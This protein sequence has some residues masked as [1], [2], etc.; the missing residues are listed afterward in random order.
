MVCMNLNSKYLI[1]HGNL[2][3]Y[4]CLKVE[5][6]VPALLKYLE[7]TRTKS[8]ELLK[9]NDFIW[10]QMALKKIPQPDRKPKRM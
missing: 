3:K 10:V 6:A 7:K 9:E 1:L 8:L 2:Q 4:F 5:A